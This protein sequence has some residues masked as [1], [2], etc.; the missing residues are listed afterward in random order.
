MDEML[1]VQKAVI[2]QYELAVQQFEDKVAAQSIQLNEK[3]KII[4]LKEK[5]ITDMESQCRKKRII[6]YAVAGG[7]IILAILL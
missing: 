3:S 1:G 7:I 2:Y 5:I 6:A 4:E